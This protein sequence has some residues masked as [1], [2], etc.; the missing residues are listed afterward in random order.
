MKPDHKLTTGQIVD[1]LKKEKE[2]EENLRASIRSTM[3][4][5]CSKPNWR[6]CWAWTIR[7][8]I[9]FRGTG[10]VRACYPN[11]SS[12]PAAASS[13]RKTSSTG[14]SRPPTT[15]LPKSSTAPSWLPASRSSS[16]ASSL[17]AGSYRLWESE[18]CL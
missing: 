17:S 16:S 3:N 6:I 5:Y 4:I 13:T 12:N 10:R 15:R 2:E 11:H 14:S 7:T 18:S 1:L 8:P 9:P